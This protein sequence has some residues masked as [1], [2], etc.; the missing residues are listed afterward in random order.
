MLNRC[1]VPPDQIHALLHTLGGPQAIRR[2]ILHV[3]EQAFNRTGRDMKARIRR[4]IVDQDV[5]VGACDPAIAEDNI[6]NVSG[7]L[8]ALRGYEISAG[9]SNDTPRISKIRQKKIQ[10]ITQTGRRVPDPMGKVEPAPH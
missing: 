6:A 3:I 4:S 2:R 5:P 9:F 10:H 8:N 7:S 1:P